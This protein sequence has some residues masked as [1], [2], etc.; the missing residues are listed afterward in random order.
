MQSNCDI[1]SF[2]DDCNAR[3]KKDIQSGWGTI[4]LF[5]A[6]TFLTMI[7]WDANVGLQLKK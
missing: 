3:Q 2:F 7:G 6:W 4:I 1:E 5:D